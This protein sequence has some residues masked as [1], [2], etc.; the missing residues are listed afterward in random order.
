MNVQMLDHKRKVVDVFNIPGTSSTTSAADD[1]H[2]EDELITRDNE[3]AAKQFTENNLFTENGDNMLLNKSNI[4]DS[5]QNR[6]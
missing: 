2:Q 4:E 5:E 1:I 3:L 6:Y